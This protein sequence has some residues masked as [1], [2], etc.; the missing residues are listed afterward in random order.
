MRIRRSLPGNKIGYRVILGNLFWEIERAKIFTWITVIHT[1]L[2]ARTDE[3]KR[4]T[5]VVRLADML[6]LEY[7]QKLQTLLE[8]YRYIAE[9]FDNLSSVP[10]TIAET[11][12]DNR[13]RQLILQMWL[14]DITLSGQEILRRLNRRS[15]VAN[16]SIEKVR[17]LMR[18]VDFWPVRMALAK[19]YRK[20]QYRKST[21][22]VIDKYRQT[23]NYLLTQ[24]AQG[25][26]WSK[27]EIDEYL[28]ALPESIRPAQQGPHGTLGQ[29]VSKSWLKCFLFGLP[30]VVDNQPCCPKC[31][32]FNTT[33]RSSTPVIQT[34]SDLDTGRPQQVATFR[35]RCNN[36]LCSCV[37]FTAPIEDTH[38]L[39]QARFAKACLM[40]RQ[41]MVLH[42]PYRALAN[43]LGTTKSVVFNELTYISHMAEH[44]DEILGPVR[45]SGT[46]CIDEKHVKIAAF[47]KFKKR[48]FGY[49]S[50]AV[51]PATG[52]LLHVEVFAASNKESA[53]AFL[54]QLKAKGIYP[55]TIM[56]DLTENYDQPVRRVYGRSVTM[57]RCFFHFKQNIFKHMHD[58]F[59]K[60]D[61]PQIA[62]DL[63]EAIFDVLRRSRCQ[64]KKDHQKTL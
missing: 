47:K 24:L 60:K 15:D 37:T 31:G 19:Q 39:E 51:D 43:L 5:G 6:G 54:M 36:P 46:I 10:E 26:S 3:N 50:L 8:R 25:K 58:Q 59:G 61:V 16:I 14:E 64:I 53:E 57:A 48:P 56:T 55:T 63:K 12:A 49:L 38:I 52:D 44:W 17:R 42:A 40:L 1:L 21:E 45:F 41:V 27:A 29:P 2:T 32:S 20:G 4:I 62:E 28:G 7:Y 34:V 33:R 22:W 13:L 23:I 30:K 11:T 9:R 18:D 35:F